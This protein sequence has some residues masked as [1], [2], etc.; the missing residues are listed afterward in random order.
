LKEGLVL[1]NSQTQEAAIF[2]WSL[3]RISL[4]GLWFS[5]FMPHPAVT[6]CRCLK[7]CS[8]AKITFLVF[9]GQGQDLILAKGLLQALTAIV[10]PW[11]V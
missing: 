5:C 11:S 1:I 9:A 4:T 2:Y 6:A 3:P 7:V 10:G 8:E